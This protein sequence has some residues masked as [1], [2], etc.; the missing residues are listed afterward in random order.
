MRVLLALLMAALLLGDVFRGL[1]LLH[2]RHVL[3]AEHGELVDAEDVG[4]ASPGAAGHA[5][6]LP[7]DGDGHHHEHCGLS[8]APARSAHLC[9]ASATASVVPRPVSTLLRAG[10]VHVAATRAVLT[11]A[12]K[13]SPPAARAA[14]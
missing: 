9:V 14:T 2:A 8:A 6:A 10:H 11:Y 7:G 1:H 13:Q 5:E 3:C 12:P 4:T